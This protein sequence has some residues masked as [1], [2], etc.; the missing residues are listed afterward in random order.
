MLQ[1]KH[2]VF[3]LGLLAAALH[4][5]SFEAASVKASATSTG[6]FTMTGGPGT[7][8]PGRITYGNIPLRRV[9]LAA[10]DLNNYQITGPDW[11]N[12][13][14]YDIS[15]TMPAGTT[16][17]QF[18]AMLRNLL[19]SRFQ[20]VSHRESKELPVYELTPG[21]SGPKLHAVSA[22]VRAAELPEQLAEVKPGTGKDGLPEVTLRSPGIVIE[23]MNG[24]ARITAHDVPLAKFGDFLSGRLDR[25]VLDK[26]GLAGNFSFV[27]YFRPNGVDA[28]DAVDP[29]IFIAVQEQLGLRLEPRRSAVELLIIDSAE[30]LPTGN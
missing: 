9:L 7:T 26:S 17:E 15:A 4:A 14:R 25:P 20:M 11:L 28:G 6:R 29:D 3:C 24:R 2:S 21:K 19:A 23:T 5:Q 22:D 18:Q 1:K 12:S 27:L 13:L 16:K 10:Y 8:D 30:K